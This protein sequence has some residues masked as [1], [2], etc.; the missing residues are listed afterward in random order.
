MRFGIREIV[1][2]LILLG[3]VGGYYAALAQPRQKDRQEWKDNITTVE[4]KIESVKK[5]T[6]GIDDVEAEIAKLQNAVA[7]FQSMLPSDREVETLLREVWDLAGEHRLNAKSVRPDKPVATAQYAEL[8]IKMEIIGDFDG[9]YDFMRDIE[10]LPRITRMP[11]IK[12][13]RQ[14]NAEGV[15]V[16]TATLTLSIFFEGA[17]AASARS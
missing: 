7:H 15:G 13:K 14:T 4:S 8:P 17:E 3:I 6:A 12:I 10:K 1:F 11:Q 5:A 16:V 9:F 2:V